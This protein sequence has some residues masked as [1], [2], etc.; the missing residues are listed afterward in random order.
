MSKVKIDEQM[1][2]NILNY[3]NQI[4][5]IEQFVDAVRETVGQYLGYTGNKGFINMVREILQNGIDEIMKSDSPATKVWVSYDE[6][7]H[8]IVTEDNGKFCRV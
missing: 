1:K 6:R 5:T 7:T 3:A 8:T 2:L 4:E